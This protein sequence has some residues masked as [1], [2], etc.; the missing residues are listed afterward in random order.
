ME[1]LL[2]KALDP[3]LGGV[4]LA[5]GRW[6]WRVEN[7]VKLSEAAREKLCHHGWEPLQTRLRRVRVR[8]MVRAGMPQVW[9]DA[10]RRGL[11]GSRGAEP[12]VMRPRGR[13]PVGRAAPL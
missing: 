1:E 3:V 6:M 11:L 7:R 10:L 12:A 13:A 2:L 8:H 4:L 9:R 5:A